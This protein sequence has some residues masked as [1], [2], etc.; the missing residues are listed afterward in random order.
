MNEVSSQQRRCG[1][2]AF[3][4]YVSLRGSGGGWAI[5]AAMPIVQR[6]RKKDR[7]S[8]SRTFV[9][10]AIAPPLFRSTYA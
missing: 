8:Q 4:Y 3:S 6:R 10:A 7:T 9:V 2:L 5:P 1:R